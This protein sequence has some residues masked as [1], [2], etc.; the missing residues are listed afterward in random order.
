MPVNLG[1]I[2]FGGGVRINLACES[3]LEGLY[4]AGD[5]TSGPG[6]GVEGFCAYGMPFATTSGAIAGRSAAAS[7][8][9]IKHPHPLDSSVV[10]E[11]KGRLLEPLL[12]KQG[13][14]PDLL[15]L[16]VQEILLPMEAYLLRHGDRLAR[17]VEQVEDLKANLLPTLKAY[18]PHYLRMAIEARNMLFCAECFLKSALLRKES[19]GSH[20]RLDYPFTDNDHWLKWIISRQVDGKVRL[21]TETIPIQ[22]YPLKPSVGLVKHPIIEANERYH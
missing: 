4:A 14:E 18:D 10:R 7:I 16:R 9:R 8:G 13:E 6:A 2:G 21:R 22:R 20:L 17:G 1:T 3:N 19:R 11:K 15:T 5:A 12:R